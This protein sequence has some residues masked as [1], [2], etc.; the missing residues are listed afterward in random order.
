MG[1]YVLSIDTSSESTGKKN[2]PD[3][4]EKRKNVRIPI[5]VPI[6]CVSVD[7]ESM[8]LDHN[9]GIVKDVSQAGLGIE[10]ATDVN[11]NRLILAFVDLNDK[12]AEIVGKVM[13][14]Q[15]TSAGTFKI[16]VL[17]QGKDSDIIEFVK[18]LV[19]FHH[20]TKKT[21]CIN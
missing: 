16:G 11:S 15:K 17:L 5:G 4:I 9:M 8:P 20:Y 12:I 10:A 18:K 1:R 21:K 13:F 6:S 2:N 14:S 7:S 19:R 3:C